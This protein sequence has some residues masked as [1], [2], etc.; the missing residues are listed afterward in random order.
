[1]GPGSCGRLRRHHNIQS[2]LQS[3]GPVSFSAWRLLGSQLGASPEP[4]PLGV[5]ESPPSL[6]ARA[7]PCPAAAYM[8][9]LAGGGGGVSRPPPL[10]GWPLGG[11]RWLRLLR[12]APFSR[13][14]PPGGV[15]SCRAYPIAWHR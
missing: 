8:R 13:R 6:H 5:W 4:E 1:M 2:G 11:L 7:A 9:I 10:E 14:H 15:C 3:Q 12:P